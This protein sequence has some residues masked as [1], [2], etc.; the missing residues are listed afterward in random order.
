MALPE[1]IG[2]KI[3]FPMFPMIWDG[4]KW[5]AIS[6]ATFDGILT[7]LEII[8]GFADA[9]NLIF[10]YNNRYEEKGEDDNAPS[11]GAD[12][13]LSAVPAD[14]IWVISSIWAGNWTRGCNVWLKIVCGA[15]IHFVHFEATGGAAQ[16]AVVTGAFVM[17]YED[18]VRVTY[19][20]LTAGDDLK[21]GALGYKMKIS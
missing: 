19:S 10:G 4:S 17:K 13:S 20:G 2:D 9:Q 8:D 12:K 7:A 6:K 14:E 18:F 5:V 11:G 16:V 21:W 1:I 3:G 15:N